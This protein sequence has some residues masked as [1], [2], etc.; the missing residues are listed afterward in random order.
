MRLCPPAAQIERV[1][2]RCDIAIVGAGAAGLAAAIFAAESTPPQRR[3]IVVLDGARSVGAKILVS[4]GGRCNVTH[5]EV[6]PEDFNGSPKIV[7]NILAAFD[8]K[9]TVQWFESLGVRLKREETGKLFP[10]S[11]SA[12]SVLAALLRRAEDLGVQLLSDRRVRGVTRVEDGFAIAHSH[13]ELHAA[14]L[15]LATGGR[16]LPKTGS[17]GTAYAF[18]QTLGHTITDTHPALV[19]LVLDAAFFHAEIS[20][21]S[22][23][24]ELST[25]ADNK[26]IDRRDGSL[27]WTHFGVSGP[28]VMDASRHWV[29]AQAQQR[30][31]RMLLN[32]YPGQDFAQVEARWIGETA[33]RPRTAATALLAERLPQRLA[34]VLLRHANIEPST[35]LSQLSRDAR[36]SLV[37]ALVGLPL[38]VLHD[39]GWNYAEV[40]AGGVPLG[41]IDFRTMQS[42][43][44]GG[45]YLVDELLDCDGRIGGFNFQWAWATGYVAGRALSQAAG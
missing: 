33:A 45:L 41:E 32:F 44:T 7:R 16:S 37:H 31:P 22:H 42:R 19:P 11:D 6:R 30:S 3:S 15:V 23:P 35:L 40:T 12:R 14:R 27:L 29:I 38:P 20:G 36:R 34:G 5:D 8:E 25:F 13:G 4:G 21:L 28:V 9:Q 17:D 18:A 2:P 10:V 39:R 1:S 24:A 26:L 43:K